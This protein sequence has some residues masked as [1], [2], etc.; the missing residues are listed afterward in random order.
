MKSIGKRVRNVVILLLPVSLIAAAPASAPLRLEVDLS[1]RKLYVHHGSTTIDTFDVAIGQPGH[2]TPTGEY[3]IDR[4]IWNPR[5][6]PPD[7]EW[8]KGEER[9][10]PGD[11]A[12][13]MQ[14]AKLFFRY[15]AYYIH[16][17]NAP[18]SIGEAASHGCIRMWPDEV[19]RLARMVQQHGGEPRDDTWY[20]AMI[21]SDK[22]REAV[23]LSEPVPITIH[24]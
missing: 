9:K 22:N 4:I 11:P 24:Q 5:W 12:N 2:R 19:E 8:A 10:E 14:G 13:P 20:E 6:V 3:S 18:A 23:R 16:G 15:P 21:R 1:E 17:T 7:S